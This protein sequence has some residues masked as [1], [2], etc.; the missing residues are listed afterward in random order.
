MLFTPA[1]TKA[2][3]YTSQTAIEVNQI[4][5]TSCGESLTK[6]LTVYI[7]KFIDEGV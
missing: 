1:K 6:T 7:G 3:E 2:A 4:A 5:K